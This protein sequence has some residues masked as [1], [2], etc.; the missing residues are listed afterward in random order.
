MA[1]QV[2]ARLKGD[3]YQHLYAWLMML[4]LKMPSK[5]L[6]KVAVEDSSAGSADDVTLEY[7]DGAASP[8]Q[9][10]QIKYHVDHRGEYSTDM[11]TSRGDGKSSL[12]EKMWLTW[13][14]LTDQDPERPVELRLLSNWTWA[15]S[16][17]FRAC[18]S[19]E[20]NSITDGFFSAGAKSNIGKVREHWRSHLQAPPDDFERFCRCFRLRLGFDCSD[21]LRDRVVERMEWLRLKSDELTL[22]AVAGI[23]RELVKDGKQTLTLNELDALLEKYD[24]YLPPDAERYISV[25][26]TTI[27]DQN[28]DIEPDH[29]LDWRNYFEGSPH[30]KGHSLSPAYTWNDHL[31]P[32]LEELESRVNCDSDCRLVRARGLARLSAW[33]AFGY[34]FSEVARYAIEVD[35]NGRLWRT[36]AETAGDF[37][38]VITSA[39]GAKGERVSGTGATVAIGISVTGSLNDDVR[40][41][42]SEQTEP[43]SALLFVRPERELGRDCIQSAAD[44]VALADGV[45]ELARGFVKHWGA[46]NLQLYYFGPLSGA[47]FIGHRLNAVCREIQIMEDQQPG[48]A[49]SFL[50]R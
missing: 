48:Y 30:K 34:T 8:N 35:Q 26:L 32:E 40:K 46:T 31:L 23:V 44:A 10:Y 3:D 41:Y 28:F 6:Q 29:V 22:V 47:C 13:K 15:S 27:K 17:P 7:A 49:P 5:E 9:F 14:M 38:L 33:F 50:L 1:N 16:D 36:D 25:Y 21:E 12:L 2:G 11:I 20:D 45:K 42:I 39:G 19:G 43:P 37:S 24:L 18:I 4:E